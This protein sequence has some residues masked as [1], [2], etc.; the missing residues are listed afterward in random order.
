M[1]NERD[2]LTQSFEVG[3]YFVFFQLNRRNTPAMDVEQDSPDEVMIL[4][5]SFLP[6]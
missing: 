6:A 2:S 4:Q 5:P 3:K 1:K